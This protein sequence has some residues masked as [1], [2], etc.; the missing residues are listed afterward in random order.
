[1]AQICQSHFCQQLDF[2]KNAEEN[3]KVR[4]LN[5]VERLNELEAIVYERAQHLKPELREEVSLKIVVL[6]FL[7]HNL[8]PSSTERKRK[9]EAGFLEVA[10]AAYSSNERLQAQSETSNAESLTELPLPKR[11][12]PTHT[13]DE[14]LE[15]RF[16]KL[17]GSACGTCGGRCCNQGGDNAFLDNEKF[18]EIFSS[19][20][21]ATPEGV[22]A[23]YMDRIP[24]ESFEGSCIF[25]GLHG[26]TLAPEQRAG[27]CNRYLCPSLVVLLRACI[28]QGSSRFLLAATNMRELD[29]PEPKVFRITLADDRDESVLESA[30]DDRIPASE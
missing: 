7:P 25:H 12:L 20:P 22:V 28:S 3:Q 8:E 15:K 26:C 11:K 27:I 23:E 21:D 2:N 19:R 16:A 1:M 30:P 9:V 29:D 13:N 10:I 4:E 5:R 6:P 17:N 14:R 24:A 18:V